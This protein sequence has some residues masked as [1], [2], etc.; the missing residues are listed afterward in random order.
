MLQN[1]KMCWQ[2]EILSHWQLK[3]C[4]KKNQTCLN[5]LTNEIVFIGNDLIT[6]K[7]LGEDLLGLDRYCFYKLFLAFF[8]SSRGGFGG[9]CQ[10]MF[11]QVFVSSPGGSNP[12]W[13]MVPHSGPATY[14][15]VLY[16]YVSCKAEKSYNHSSISLQ[17]RPWHKWCTI[18]IKSKQN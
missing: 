11:T 8:K 17:N 15:R 14:R 12:A 18:I 3:N 6:K 9:K 10:T 5:L 1:M 4:T 2:W 13:G 7:Q 16:M